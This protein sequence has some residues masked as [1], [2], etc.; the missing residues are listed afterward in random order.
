MS[1]PRFSVRVSLVVASLIAA[2]WGQVRGIS[3]HGHPAPDLERAWTAMRCPGTFRLSAAELLYPTPLQRV[4]RPSQ[5]ASVGEDGDGNLVLTSADGRAINLNGVDIL[6]IIQQQ[7]R[8]QAQNKSKFYKS[9]CFLSVRHYTAHI[10]CSRHTCTAV[11]LLCTAHGAQQSTIAELRA[12]IE[13]R[14]N[15]SC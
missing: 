5:S 1:L 8:T 4:P 2:T 3:P 10:A 9:A 13:S 14:Y 15:F 12:E 6:S 11:T 7:V